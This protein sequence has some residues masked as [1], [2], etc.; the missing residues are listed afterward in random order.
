MLKDLVK[1]R[2]ATVQETVRIREKSGNCVLSQGELTFGREVWQIG[3]FYS[4]DLFVSKTKIP[5]HFFY[6]HFF[7]QW[8]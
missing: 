8:W 6:F 7:F 5:V 4:I 1:R 3:N 2:V